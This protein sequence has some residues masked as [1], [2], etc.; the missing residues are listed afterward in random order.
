MA[1]I[2]QRKLSGT[3][4]S[5]GSAPGATNGRDQSA[6]ARLGRFAVRRRFAII[7]VWVVRLLFG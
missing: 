5:V 6:F 1:R 2:R 7:A 4:R 3:D